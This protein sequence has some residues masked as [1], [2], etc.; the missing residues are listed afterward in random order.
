MPALVPGLVQG[1]ARSPEQFTRLF[2]GLDLVGAAVGRAC[3]WRPEPS[4]FTIREVP[5]WGSVG[6]KR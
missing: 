2:G 3:R 6:R 5:A 4:P 1:G